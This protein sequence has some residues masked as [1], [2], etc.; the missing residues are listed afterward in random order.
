M[1]SPEQPIAAAKPSI[2]AGQAWPTTEQRTG[3]ADGGQVL[4]DALELPRRQ[5]H[6]GVVLGLRDAQVLRVNVHQL[7]VELGQPLL[8]CGV[9]RGRV[10]G[11]VLSGRAARGGG[12]PA[13]CWPRG[14][15]LSRHT[16]G[17][18]LMPCMVVQ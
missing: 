3:V 6:G 12:G 4:D 5:L 7:Q 18:S 14:M 11:K 16:A 13:A 8:V 1:L 15:V 2:A 9:C 17:P 10:G